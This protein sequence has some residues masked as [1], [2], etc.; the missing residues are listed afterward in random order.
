[1]AG[2]LDRAANGIG[3]QEKTTSYRKPHVTDNV[4]ITEKPGKPVPVRQF[5]LPFRPVDDR[6][7]KCDR[8]A[9]GGIE[10]LIVVGKIVYI[11]SEIVRVQTELA[12]ETFSG[13]DFEVVAVGRLDRQPQHVGI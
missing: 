9:Y 12:E 2:E 13:S 11:A 4:R 6:F 3:A 1:M 8:K 5:E 10:D 7:T